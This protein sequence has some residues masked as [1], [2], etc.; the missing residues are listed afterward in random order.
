MRAK[1]KSSVTT[2]LWEI[3]T[4]TTVMAA[5]CCLTCAVYVNARR[6]EPHEDRARA[7]AL[8]RACIRLSYSH[9][10]SRA[11]S[12]L[13]LEFQVRVDAFRKRHTSV[14]ACDAPRPN[15]VASEYGRRWMLA[16]SPPPYVRVDVSDFEP[17]GSGGCTVDTGRAHA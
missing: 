7:C 12:V 15:T 6:A 2:Y 4:R 17:P 9:G 1:F 5:A 13:C 11:R 16:S 3:R 10:C 14:S 8:R